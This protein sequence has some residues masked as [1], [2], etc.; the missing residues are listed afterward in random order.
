MLSPAVLGREL[1]RG[2][3]ASSIINGGVDLADEFIWSGRVIV[4]THCDW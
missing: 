1:L 4:C 2:L 3:C